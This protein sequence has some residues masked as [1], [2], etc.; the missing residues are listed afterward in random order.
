MAIPLLLHGSPS[1]TVYRE[2]RR[3]PKGKAIS[4]KTIEPIRHAADT[5]NWKDY[6][7]VGR[8]IKGIVTNVSI[9]SK[10]HRMINNVYNVTTET[11]LK[12]RLVEWTRQ[13]KG[14]AEKLN[15]KDNINVGAGELSW[16]SGKNCTPI[17]AGSRAELLL[18]MMGTSKNAVD[19][20]IKD[21]N[22]GKRISRNGRIYQIRDGQLQVLNF[23]EQIKHD[24]RLAIESLAKTY[25]QK[26]GSW[27]ITEAH[28]QQAR[29]YVEL[30]YKY[31]QLDGRNTPNNTHTQ[32]GSVTIGDWDLVTLV[33][34]GSASAISDND[35]LALDMMA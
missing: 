8:R 32:N 26:A 11:S 33:K 4:D 16:A 18:D 35:W 5:A 1:V 25:S 6:A 31:A 17:V 15:A 34:Q 29:E 13:L 2:L 27:H 23:D 21:L 24:Q 9:E 20:V 22:S 10:L 28:W 19:E 7:E 3:M 30:A 14:T 12:T